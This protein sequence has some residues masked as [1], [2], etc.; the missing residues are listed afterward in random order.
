IIEDPTVVYVDIEESS[1]SENNK[2]IAKGTTAAHFMKF[3]NELLDIMDTD[4]SLIGS[5]LVMDNCIIY[6][7]HP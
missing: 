6:K 1:T 3:M 2:P 7:S 4:E 5:Y